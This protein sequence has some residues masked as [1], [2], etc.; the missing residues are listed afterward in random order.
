MSLCLEKKLTLAGKVHT[1]P[2]ELVSFEP[3]FGILRYVVDREYLIGD[4]RLLPGDVTCAFYWQD[5][6]YTLYTWRLL[7]DGS[8][9]Y[10][11]N[12][13]DSVS[14]HPREFIWR[15]LVL[16]ILIDAQ[17]SAHVLDEDELPEDLDADVARYIQRAKD[18]ILLHFRDIIREAEVLLVPCSTA[19]S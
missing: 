13:A 3:G 19:G 12:I 5:R 10:Y 15:D 14:L 8:T 7:R 1:F 9:L 18:H 2:C 11:F 4:T 17:G 16:D 6:P